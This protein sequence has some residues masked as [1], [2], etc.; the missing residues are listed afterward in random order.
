MMM[1]M[2]MRTTT[3]ICESSGFIIDNETHDYIMG[4][5]DQEKESI[6]ILI[7][8]SVKGYAGNHSI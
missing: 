1:M 7:T 6:A 5:W 2:M 4:L 3:M 8:S